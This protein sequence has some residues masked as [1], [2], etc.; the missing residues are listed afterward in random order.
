MAVFTV[1]IQMDIV[2]INEVGVFKDFIHLFERQ[3]EHK[4]MTGRG[5]GLA[6]GE[7]DADSPLSIEPVAELVEV[8]V[9]QDS[10]RGSVRLHVGL[11]V[12]F[13]P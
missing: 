13:D 1:Y 2:I 12:G 5:S 7:G 6:E 11:H 10:M 9:M 3:R 8:D 4:R